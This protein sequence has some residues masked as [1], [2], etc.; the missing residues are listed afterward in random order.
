[1]NHISSTSEHNPQ[2]HTISSPTQTRTPSPTLSKVENNDTW[3]T[4]ECGL[5]VIMILIAIP[6]VWMNERKQVK[7]DK[8]IT[9]GKKEVIEV[10]HY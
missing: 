1:M 3:G 4:K 7:I 2:T 5:G 9:K 10:D 8:L 6:M